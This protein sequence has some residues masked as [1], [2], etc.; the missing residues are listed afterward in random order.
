MIRLNVGCGGMIMPD[1]INIDPSPWDGCKAD[2]IADMNAL[3]FDAGTVDEILT[4]H[5]IEH[6]FRWDAVRALEHWHALLKPG[7]RLVIETPRRKAV[8]FGYLFLPW[9][10][11]VSD[12]GLVF[13]DGFYGDVKSQDELLVHKYL[14]EA[15]ELV[16]EL[17]W[18]GF[19]NVRWT[20]FTKTHIPL[21]DMRVTAEKS[22][23]ADDE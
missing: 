5:V 18:L 7:G 21:R 8:C 20:P 12:H 17:R 23:E 3:P 15:I 9:L 19:V 14:W 2:V 22:K 1:Y 4:Y 13:S 16:R 6:V 11:R 10:R